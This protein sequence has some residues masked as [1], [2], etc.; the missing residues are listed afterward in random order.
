MNRTTF[1][2]TPVNGDGSITLDLTAIDEQFVPVGDTRKRR[3]IGS[4]ELLVIL[5][6]IATLLF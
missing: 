5:A 6:A 1:T 4:S 3:I 2:V